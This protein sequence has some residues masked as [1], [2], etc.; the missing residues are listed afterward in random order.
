[1]LAP[2]TAL[3][4]SGC[5]LARLREEPPEPRSTER[6]FEDCRRGSSEHYRT[7]PALGKAAWFLLTGDDDES[8]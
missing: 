7:G 2:A 6:Y 4:L 3:A 8:D 1:V 5:G